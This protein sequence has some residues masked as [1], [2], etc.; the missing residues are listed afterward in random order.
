[1]LAEVR[2]IIAPSEARLVMTRG[3]KVIEDERWKFERRI[4]AT[5]AAGLAEAA[6]SDAYDLMQYAVHGDE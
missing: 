4:T 5:E 1:M 3:D 2:L 6:F